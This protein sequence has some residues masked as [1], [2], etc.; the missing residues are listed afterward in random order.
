MRRE[1]S[2]QLTGRVRMTRIRTRAAILTAAALLASCAG[3]D[4]RYAGG[5]GDAR[6][7]QQSAPAATPERAIVEAE[8]PPSI[9]SLPVSADSEE[10][11]MVTANR[12]ARPELNSNSPMVT[13]DE[14]FLGQ[15][16]AAAVE[17]QPNKLPQF[18]VSQSSSTADMRAGPMPPQL[19]GRDRF[20]SVD[21][22]PFQV[23]AQE[24]VSTFSIDVDTASYGWVRASLNRNVLPQ[25][26]AVRTEEMVRGPRRVRSA[27]A[28][29]CS[30]A[31]GP[32]GASSCASASAATISAAKRGRGP[33][34]C[35]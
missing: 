32:K 1:Y 11:I 29:T 26:A 34:W 35:S 17:Q 7:A 19:Q 9:A 33:T 18:A 25:P 30:R 16:I 15:S 28:S 5:P 14:Q 6:M 10:T 27:P 24:P 21:Q 23:V 4:G 20:T 13:V 31:L 2:A 22:N 12:I 3:A 8:P